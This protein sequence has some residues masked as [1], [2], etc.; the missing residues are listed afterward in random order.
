M[1][2]GT[3]CTGDI[4]HI[5]WWCL[6][7][8]LGSD[9]HTHSHTLS[10]SQSV[11]QSHGLRKEEQLKLKQSEKGIQVIN[12]CYQSTNITVHIDTI[13]TQSIF[14]LILSF[15]PCYSHSSISNTLRNLKSINFQI[16]SNILFGFSCLGGMRPP[17]LA[18][19]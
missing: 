19:L 2:Y 3:V 7:L 9:T 10:V 18:P 8:L 4:I 12:M 11:S 5:T 6:Q 15:A 17:G 14:I 16:C 13:F 1:S